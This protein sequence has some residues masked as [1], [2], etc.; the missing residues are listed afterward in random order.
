MANFRMAVDPQPRLNLYTVGSVG[1]GFAATVLNFQVPDDA[2]N[3]RRGPP[4]ALHGLRSPR[5]AGACSR[6]PAYGSR[7]SGRPASGIDYR[8]GTRSHAMP[9]TPAYWP[10]SRRTAPCQNQNKPAV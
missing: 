1:C 2:T 4:P 10:L 8:T 6:I 3:A 7:T 9:R 5:A